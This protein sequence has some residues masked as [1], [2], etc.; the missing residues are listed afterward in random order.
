MAEID[1]ER[2]NYTQLLQTPAELDFV[3]DESHSD[4]EL[5]LH[6]VAQHDHELYGMD[7]SL[8]DLFGV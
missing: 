8:T 7:C 4:D 6:H 2:E 1:T 5:I 3:I